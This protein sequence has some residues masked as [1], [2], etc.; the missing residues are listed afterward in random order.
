M[1][2]N[3]NLITEELQFKIDILKVK[4]NK[5]GKESKSPKFLLQGNVCQIFWAWQPK[6]D[7]ALGPL[8][9]TAMEEPRETVQ[10]ARE[11]LSFL[12]HLDAA[13]SVAPAHSGL[14]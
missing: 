1:I 12:I 7:A 8:S 14:R 3:L 11:P 6:T 13:W 4:P 10:A 9:P 2:K 5:D